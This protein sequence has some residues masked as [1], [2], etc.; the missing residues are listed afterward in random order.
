[1]KWNIGNVE[2][3]NQIVLAPMAGIC[4]S[5]Y[6]TIIKQ[7]GCGLIETEM[8]SDKAL[9]N[10]N[11]KTQQM[12]YMTN[13]ERPISIQLLGSQ[14]ETLTQAAK[15]IYQYNKPDIIDINMGCPDDKVVKHAHAG[16]WLLKNP[17]KAYNIIKTLTE[18]ISVPITAKIRSGYNCKQINAIEIAQTLE[19][20]GLSAI[21]IH[22]R[23]RTQGYDIKSDWE[24]IKEIKETVNIPVIGNG[25]IKTCYDAKKM[26]DTTNC[27]AVMIGRAVLGNPWLIKQCIQYIEEDKKPEPVTINEK[28]EVLKKHANLIYKT[29]LEKD[30]LPKLRM[31]AVYYIKT[32]PGAKKIKQEIFKQNTKEDIINLIETYMESFNY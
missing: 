24:I 3:N 18:T 1:M 28:I 16:S 6:R 9:I 10:K 20:A 27:D 26:I 23:T 15:I 29:Q 4:D 12:L 19:E 21:T 7:M 32:L 30:A 5:A 13:Y 11:R 31:H 17:E 2:I 14:P 8:I 25:D 22:P